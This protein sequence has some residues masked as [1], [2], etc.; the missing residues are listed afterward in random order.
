MAKLVKGDKFPCAKVNTLKGEEVCVSTLAGKSGK[1]AF[2]FLRYY[3]CSLS[4][5]DVSTYAGIYADIKAKGNELVIA[6]QSTAESIAR[7]CPI[8]IPFNVI[9]D[10]D[11]KLYQQLEIM[12]AE[13][14]QKALSGMTGEKIQHLRETT[15]IKHGDYEGI[16]EQLPAYFVVDAD[17]NVLLAHYSAE[18]G[19][20]P[21]PEDFEKL[22]A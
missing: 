11:A 5:F 10:P 1:T 7:Q 2:I 17:M 13:D 9:C 19:D 3:G 14:F 22:F 12:P 20:V 4:Q 21:T 18:L 16:E 15:D 6:L 8:D